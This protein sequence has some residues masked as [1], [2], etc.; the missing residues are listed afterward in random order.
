V[1][2]LLA[3]KIILNKNLQHFDGAELQP[4]KYIDDDGKQ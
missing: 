1:K 3:R 4:A 2:G